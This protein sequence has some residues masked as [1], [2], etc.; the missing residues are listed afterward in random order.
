MKFIFLLSFVFCKVLFAQNDLIYLEHADTLKSV[1][2]FG[3]TEKIL[4]GNISIVQENSSILSDFA[5]Y[6][7]KTG[8]ASS[9][10]N[11]KII[12]ST[13]TLFC[14]SLVYSKN[15]GVYECRR[16][17]VYEDKNYNL[18]SPNIDY[19][20]KEKSFKAYNFATLRDKNTKIFAREIF[21]SDLLKRATAKGNVSVY[22]DSSKVSLNCNN[23]VYQLDTKIIIALE[24][25]VLIKLDSLRKETVRITSKKMEAF[26]DSNYVLITDSVLIKSQEFEAICDSAFYYTKKKKIFL[27]VNPKIKQKENYLEGQRIELTLQSN[28]KLDTVFVSGKALAKSFS[29]KAGKE[30]LM[31]G[32]EITMTFVDGN[33]NQALINQNAES[34]YYFE[35]KTGANKISGSFIKLSFD[36][37]KVVDIEVRTGSQGTYFPKKFQEKIKLETH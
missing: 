20:S 3:I 6:N 12:D 29:E 9:W 7:E 35:D 15:T 13:K 14:D 34:I 19:F 17:V 37:K 30:N 1:T 10:G 27:L 25:P 11:V 21:H 24:N 16:N 31:R 2:S 4:V 33:T 22:N 18:V 28:E 26:I 23:L 5:K 8:I 36:K 32:K